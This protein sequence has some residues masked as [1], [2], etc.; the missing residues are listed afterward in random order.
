MMLMSWIAVLVA[1]ADVQRAAGS[2][3]RIVDGSERPN[4][5]AV[6]DILPHN[7][8]AECGAECGSAYLSS[9]GCLFAICYLLLVA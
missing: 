3:A 9:K 4:I 6:T 7:Y 1:V 2:I 8:N 5:S